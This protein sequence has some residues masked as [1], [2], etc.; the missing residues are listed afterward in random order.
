MLPQT[1]TITLENGAVLNVVSTC[2]EPPIPIRIYDFCA[3]ED[4]QEEFG[5]YGWGLTREEAIEDLRNLLN[6][7]LCAPTAELVGDTN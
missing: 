4:G 6:E 5:E 1:H 7:E 2:E 3:Y